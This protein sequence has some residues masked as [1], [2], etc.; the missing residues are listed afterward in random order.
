MWHDKRSIKNFF[1][2]ALAE[3]LIS[4]ELSGLWFKKYEE[5]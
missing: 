2:D 3:Q 5:A 1:S 4:A